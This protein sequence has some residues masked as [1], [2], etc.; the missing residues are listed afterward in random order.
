MQR[1]P[2]STDTIRYD[3]LPLLDTILFPIQ[4]CNSVVPINRLIDL[5]IFSSKFDDQ[6]QFLKTNFFFRLFA[7]DYIFCF[8]YVELKDVLSVFPSLFLPCFCRYHPEISWKMHNT[9]CVMH[10]GKGQCAR[11]T[12]PIKYWSLITMAEQ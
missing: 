12:S 10:R 7:Y 6:Y 1:Y 3:T 2:D 5:T 9:W 4:Y 11:K 8:S